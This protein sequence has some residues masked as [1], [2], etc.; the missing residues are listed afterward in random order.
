MEQIFRGNLQDFLESK[1]FEIHR[2][3]RFGMT[4]VD[5][6]Y[7]DFQEKTPS[8]NF[9]NAIDVMRLDNEGTK[10]S[11]YVFKFS[12]LGNAELLLYKPST[13]YTEMPEWVAKNN[14][15]WIKIEEC[16][17]EKMKVILDGTIE[18]MKSHLSDI[19]TDIVEYNNQLKVDIQKLIATSNVDKK[20]EKLAEIKNYVLFGE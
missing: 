6:L 19:E 10:Q 20:D 15:L 12:V 9:D 3:I 17:I 16:E 11:H 4:D 5:E 2:L 13:S 18:T 8:V 7:D 1:K 14:E